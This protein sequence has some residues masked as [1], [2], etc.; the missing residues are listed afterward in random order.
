MNHY[1]H[2]HFPTRTNTYF[3]IQKILHFRN[4][5]YL[6]QVDE[7]STLMFEEGFNKNKK[8]C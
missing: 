2:I 5:H 8:N 4:I 3:P 1:K 6:T 7:K